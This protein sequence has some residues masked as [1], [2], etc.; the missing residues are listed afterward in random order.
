MKVVNLYFCISISLII[1]F[2]SL[3][4]KDSDE[5][6]SA[7]KSWG[8]PELIET[9]NAGNANLPQVAMDRSGN[10]IAVWKQETYNGTIDILSNCYMP[11]TG[12]GIAELIETDD[13]GDADKPVISMNNEGMAVAAWVQNDGSS[14]NINANRY[15]PETGWGTAELV[16]TDD[17]GNAYAPSVAID[18]EGNAVVVWRHHD[19]TGYNILSNFN[20]FGHKWQPNF[21]ER[22]DAG[23]NNS[24]YP[25]VAFDGKGN[26]I[27]VW[28]EWVSTS[29]SDFL[30]RR[31]IPGSGWESTVAID[32]EAS[33]GRS[34]SVALNKDGNGAA[35]WIQ[36]NS[37]RAN[38][39]DPGTG[40]G[41]A[42]FIE[43]E[44]GGTDNPLVA[45]DG[46]GNVIAVWR[47]NISGFY[48]IY[49]NRYIPGSGWGKPERIDAVDNM[50]NYL[51][52][53]MNE[54]GNAVAVWSQLE[55]TKYH[56]WSNRYYPGRGWGSAVKIAADDNPSFNPSVAIDENGNVVVVW[57]QYNGTRYDIYSCRYE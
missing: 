41:T 35:V 20:P 40:W 34:V 23:D 33:T 45:I 26:A 1:S 32:S 3:S 14:V 7:P 37:I 10:A 27:A 28:W 30:A 47:H 8:T 49:S 52:I 56:V 16:E 43:T 22:L 55:G 21:V 5:S 29:D 12:W 2:V 4:C 51:Q 42:E 46:D 17:A 6:S 18:N 11:E 54:N 31:Y 9:Y 57:S 19:L 50:A 39:Y 15:N 13:A 25:H 38:Y 53:A 48:G 36:D 44:A 24:N